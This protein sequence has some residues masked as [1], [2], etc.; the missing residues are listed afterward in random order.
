MGIS[1]Y[2]YCSITSHS[3]TQN[4]MHILHI[5]ATSLR[6]G[7]IYSIVWGHFTGHDHLREHDLLALQHCTP[8][9]LADCISNVGSS[10]DGDGPFLPL[11]VPAR[12]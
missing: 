9:H 6:L 5:G 7:V 4:E 12:C 8:K 10:H 11:A 2:K 3:W 1:R